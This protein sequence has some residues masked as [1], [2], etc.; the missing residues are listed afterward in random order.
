MGSHEG[1]HVMGFSHAHPNTKIM[2]GTPTCHMMSDGN[3]HTF[4]Y[5]EMDAL[6]TYDPTLDGTFL[7]DTVPLFN[8]CNDC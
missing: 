5:A 2:Y 4:T 8:P 1:G 7:L 3:A 6:R